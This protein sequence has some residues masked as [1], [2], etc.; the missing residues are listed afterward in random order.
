MLQASF[1]QKHFLPVSVF[2]EVDH[3]VRRVEHK[4]FPAIHPSV[5]TC[6]KSSSPFVSSS[7]TMSAS[8]NILPPTF[9]YPL[10]AAPWAEFEA[11]VYSD[12]ARVRLAAIQ[13]R[14]IR[15]TKMT[16]GMWRFRSR[17]QHKVH[18]D[19][20]VQLGAKL[21]LEEIIWRARLM[22][23]F[24]PARPSF[25][26]YATIPPSAGWPMRT[27]MVLEL[28]PNNFSMVP[29][30]DG[31]LLNHQQREQFGEDFAFADTF[32]AATKRWMQ[33]FGSFISRG[34]DEI[35]EADFNIVPV[36]SD[37]DESSLPLPVPAMM[38]EAVLNNSQDSVGSS[39]SVVAVQGSPTVAQPSVLPLAAQLAFARALELVQRP[40]SPV[41]EPADPEDEP[42]LDDTINFV[43][44]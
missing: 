6:V 30:C 31:P 28:Y 9:G 35:V 11:A 37:S 1:K 26:G 12:P 21:A 22:D 20:V 32:S 24:N 27:Y 34:W 25:L 43:E 17:H 5:S 29:R 10:E 7:A 36:D 16:V 3:H 4:L 23:P 40:L 19:E 8:P 38:V 44:E 42:M 33:D 2:S 13:R 15:L 14:P 39:S 18:D 41:G